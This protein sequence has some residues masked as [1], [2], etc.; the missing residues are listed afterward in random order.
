MFLRVTFL[1]SL[2]L[3]LVVFLGNKL[4]KELLVETP[5]LEVLGTVLFNQVFHQIFSGS[6]LT[7]AV[8]AVEL[9]FVRV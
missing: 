3:K 7:T 5:C 6:I 2:K 9:G 8:V 1:Q 4:F